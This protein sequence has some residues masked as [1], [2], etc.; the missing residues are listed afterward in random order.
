VRKGLSERLRREV[1]NTAITAVRYGRISRKNG[2]ARQNVRIFGDPGRTAGELVFRE[3]EGQWYVYA[4]DID[5]S[6]LGEAYEAPP[7]EDGPDNVSPL[8]FY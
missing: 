5:F 8:N 3:E 1:A 2:E 6:P 4:A 7:E